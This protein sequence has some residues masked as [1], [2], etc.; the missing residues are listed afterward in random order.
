MKNTLDLSQELHQLL[1]TDEDTDAIKRPLIWRRFRRQEGTTKKINCSACNP[2][3]NSGYIEGQ[4]GCPYC[5]GEGYLWDEQL[6]EGYLYK[7]NEGKDRYNLNMASEAGKTN[8]TFNVLVTL[9]DTAPVIED[10]IQV[11]SV[12]SDSRIAVPINIELSQ[13]VVYSRYLRASRNSK[14]FNISYLGG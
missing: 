10:T 14:D 2:S 13:K 7:Q 4:Y 9:F 12:D 1:F 5:S 6:I 11:L 3:E 8:S